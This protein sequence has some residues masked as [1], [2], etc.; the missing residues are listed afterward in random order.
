MV[1]AAACTVNPVAVALS[2][3]VSAGSAIRSSATWIARFDTEPDTA[4][5]AISTLTAGTPES[6]LMSP[7]PALPPEVVTASG[8]LM[9][10]P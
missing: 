3:Q 7:A 2:D 1:A 8:R 5:A 10:L 6:H 4:P 9:A